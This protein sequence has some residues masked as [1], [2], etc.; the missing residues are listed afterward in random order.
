[1]VIKRYLSWGNVLFRLACIWLPISAFL[2]FCYIFQVDSTFDIFEVFW[3]HISTLGF[4]AGIVRLHEAGLDREAVIASGRNGKRMLISNFLRRY[5]RVRVLIQGMNVFLGIFGA[6][7]E[8][9][10]QPTRPMDILLMVYSLLVIFVFN[11]D[12]IL[13]TA[14]A[15]LELRDR[16]NLRQLF[17]ATRS[18]DAAVVP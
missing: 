16:E 18:T 7:I 11:I 3:L 14:N 2:W 1:M 17:L 4:L 6:F 5:A 15:L 8:L 10:K 9:P 12:S 13:M